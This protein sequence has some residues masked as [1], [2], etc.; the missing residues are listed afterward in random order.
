MNK[1]KEVKEINI[2]EIKERA[3][4]NAKELSKILGLGLTYTYD[5]I[6]SEECPFNIIKTGKRYIIPT[7]SFLAWYESL[8]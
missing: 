6:R 1:N 5:F 4:I 2:N 3:F 7:N 8:K